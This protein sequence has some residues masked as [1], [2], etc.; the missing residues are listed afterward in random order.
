MLFI[1]NRSVR[2]VSPACITDKNNCAE[3]LAILVGLGIAL[4]WMASFWAAE[5][6]HSL[7][8]G[9][10]AREPQLFAAAAAVLLPGGGARQLD[11]RAPGGASRSRPGAARQLAPKRNIM[12]GNGGQVNSVT[13]LRIVAVLALAL[14]SQLLAADEW[15][16]VTSPHFVVLSNASRSRAWTT[17]NEFEE[18]RAVFRSA[19]SNT[20]TE[21]AR[22]IV[23]FAVRNEEAL[24]ELLPGLGEPF[25]TGVFWAA[26]DKYRIALRLDVDWSGPL[27]GHLSRVP[28]PALPIEGPART[29]LGGRRPRRVLG[30]GSHSTRQSGDRKPQSETLA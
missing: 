7:L 16:Q 9:L 20:E 29:D 3:D 22:P 17:A 4:G 28:P 10:P 25:P 13:A 11:S 18:I 15:L 14:S 21:P 19:L 26:P 6:V 24:R 12:W 5:L 8:F 27:R 30:A 23:I 2:L 1:A